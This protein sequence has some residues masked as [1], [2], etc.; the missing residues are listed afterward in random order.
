MFQNRLHPRGVAV[1]VD[2]VESKGLKPG[3]NCI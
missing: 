1:Q 2:Q 3:D